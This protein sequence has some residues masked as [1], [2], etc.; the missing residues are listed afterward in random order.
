M[1]FGVFTPTEAAVVAVVYA[2]AVGIFIYR[3]LTLRLLYQC[4]IDAAKTTSIVMLLVSA[5]FVSGW[6]IT[7]ANLPE[8]LGGLL[9]PFLEHPRLLVLVMIGIV[10]VVGMALDFTPMVL[11]LTPI[12]L[13]VAQQAG[14]DRKSTRLNSS[15]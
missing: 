7:V 8:Q 14:V 6:L 15:H 10:V 11:I 4:L 13:P 2:I 3:E 5:A 12:M 1:R 9:K